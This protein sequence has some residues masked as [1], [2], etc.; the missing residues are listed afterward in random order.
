MPRE[1]SVMTTVTPGRTPPVASTTRPRISPVVAC[2]CGKTDAAARVPP[3]ARAARRAQFFTF[4]LLQGDFDAIVLPASFP[5]QRLGRYNRRF[6]EVL[7]KV[8]LPHDQIQ[9]RIREM[10]RE[11]A[12]DY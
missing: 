12:R 11:I 6:Q 2:D 10:G 3:R 5:S 4:T 1:A 8:L 9:A 7:V